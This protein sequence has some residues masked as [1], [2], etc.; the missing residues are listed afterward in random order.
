V[1]RTILLAGGG[2]AGH[3]FPAIAVARA[4]TRLAEDVTPVFVGVEDRLEARL[5]PEAG[6]ELVTIDAASIPRRPSPALL[7]VPGALRRG[8]RSCRELIVARRAVAAVSF[9]GYVSFPL[10]RAAYREQLP[11]V[12]H[13]QNSV[14]GLTNR[15]AARWADRIAVTFPGSVPRF[16]YQERCVVTGDPV[17]AD[18][19]ELDRDSRRREARESLGLDPERA[20]L[21]VFGGSQ[22]ARSINRAVADAHGRWKGRDLQILHATGRAGLEAA[23]RAME[24]ARNDHP[25]GPTV[26]T[27]GFLEDMAAA[28]AA[29]DVVV[30]RAGATSIAELTVLGIP[31]VLVP[32]PHAT[33]DHQRENA[34]ALQ[35]VGG[36][37]VIEDDELDGSS[38]VAAVAPLLDD[39]AAA[40]AMARAARAF[41]RPDAADAVARLLLDLV[42][43]EVHP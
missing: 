4:L 5:V 43:E 23:E 33:A 9:G 6:F 13:E 20:T 2:T 8:V 1:T 32:Y 30:C 36:G 37:V 17:R 22:G 16:R 19:L 41:G 25:D 35:R 28:Y 10:N 24:K 29:A 3:V 11:M 14:P 21:L 31:S 40:V 18:V 27:V 42:P 7:R 15:V 34:A 39:P 12:I 26:R 38:L